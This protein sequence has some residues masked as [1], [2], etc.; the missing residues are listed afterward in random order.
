LRLSSV[1]ESDIFV[2]SMQLVGSYGDGIVPEDDE[3]MLAAQANMLVPPLRIK[4]G[5]ESEDLD[6]GGD[7]IGPAPV[8]PT[9][10][11]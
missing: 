2:L 7:P 6:P 11:V 8:S 10:E 5:D 9:T 4:Q 1:L 3:N